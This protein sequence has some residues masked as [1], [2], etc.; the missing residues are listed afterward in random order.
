[1]RRLLIAS[2]LLSIA[3]GKPP[4]TKKITVTDTY[5]G[6]KVV[7]EYR[8]LKNSFDGAVAQWV[9]QQNRYARTYLDAIAG[10]EAIDK[11]L[12]EL[13][14]NR[15]PSYG[16]LQSRGGRLFAL[17]FQPP[18]EQPLLVTLNSIDDKSSERVVFD[19]VS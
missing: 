1:M 8:W 10:R 12:H 9:D 13:L 4:A 3:A 7:D 5:H 11:R 2:I 15:P 14:T 16:S 6:V 18:K 17:K 19:P